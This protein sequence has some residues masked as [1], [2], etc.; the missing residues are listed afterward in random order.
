MIFGDY[1]GDQALATTPGLPRP[2]ADEFVSARLTSRPG[3]PAGR[4][5]RLQ[6]TDWTLASP[7]DLPEP[8]PRL[9]RG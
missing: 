3:E 7:S 2:A 4:V 6:G 5:V 1:A 9:P 8:A